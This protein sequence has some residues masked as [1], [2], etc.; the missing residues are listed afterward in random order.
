[1]FVEFYLLFVLDARY[2]T[3]PTFIV[4][5]LIR[6]LRL[7]CQDLRNTGELNE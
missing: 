7:Y 4:H 5:K 2:I 1:M 6:I 3:L